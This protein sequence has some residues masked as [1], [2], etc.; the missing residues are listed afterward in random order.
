M[1]AIVANCTCQTQHV[2]DCQARFTISACVGPMEHKQS[3]AY[4]AL[5][6]LRAK[7]ATPRILHTLCGSLSPGG[8]SLFLYRSQRK[9]LFHICAAR[10]VNSK[11]RSKCPSQKGS[12]ISGTAN[13]PAC[14]RRKNG[15]TEASFAGIQTQTQ[16]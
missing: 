3:R 8:L 16:Q 15:N 6:T 10:M 4:R 13:E 7:C 9:R 12:R 14:F 1:R 11:F 2:Y 5:H